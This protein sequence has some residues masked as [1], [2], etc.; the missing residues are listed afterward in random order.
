MVSPPSPKQRSFLEQGTMPQG[1]S[2]ARKNGRSNARSTRSSRSSTR[3]PW[4]S[5]GRSTRS[6]RSST[7]TPW[8]SKGSTRKGTSSTRSCRAPRSRRRNRQCQ[9]DGCPAGPRMRLYMSCGSPA[10]RKTWI[11]QRKT[12]TYE[13]HLSGEREAPTTWR[14][15]E[16]DGHRDQVAEDVQQEVAEES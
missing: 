10:T 5:K 12:A 2:K 9:E 14:P 15:K 8:R 16:A 4:R 11:S 3:T 1:S 13:K 6:S 7:R